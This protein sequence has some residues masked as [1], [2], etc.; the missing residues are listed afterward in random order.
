M[1]KKALVELYSPGIVLFDPLELMRFLKKRNV[2]DANIFNAFLE[3]EALGREAIEQGVVCPIYQ[4]SEAE[5]AV[6]AEGGNDL[7]DTLPEP[8]FVHSGLPLK[9]VSGI[10]II[11]DLNALFDWDERFFL[12]YKAEYNS[13]LPSNDYIDV[14]SGFY[15]LSIKGYSNLR[16][17]GSEFGYG[18]VFTQVQALPEIN[19]DSSIS[20]FDF[21]LVA[22]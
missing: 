22:R 6:F 11:S 10:M 2:T 16:G 18:L 15:S 5:Y 1:K 19:G 17:V 20:D 3:D 8:V 21:E 4:I 12:N 13:R 7:P 9:I 14:E